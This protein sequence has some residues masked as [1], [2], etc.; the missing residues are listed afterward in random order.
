MKPTQVLSSEHRVIEI[1]LTCL[2][3]MT[4][5]ATKQGHLDRE[6]AEQVI[7]FI[8]NFADRCHH[9]KEE[10]HLFPSLTRAG[11]PEESGPLAVMLQEHVAGR[12]YVSKMLKALDKA[13]Q[14]DQAAVN[15]FADNAYGYIQ[16][17]RGH[18]QKEDNILFRMADQVLSSE[19]QIKL[20]ESFR[21][22]ES[23][24]L[25]AKTHE[26][27]LELVRSL[28]ARY[29]VECEFLESITQ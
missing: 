18:I 1:A 12:N 20:S 8:Q 26:K 23:D 13:S 27:Y 6:P 25:G 21:K 14:G 19:D 15:T 5:R 22:V 10:D 28:A 2:E 7:D 29:D 3:R 17:L 11:M 9:G 16:L 4:D 24:H